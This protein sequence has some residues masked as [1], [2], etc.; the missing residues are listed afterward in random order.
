MHP[1]GKKKT[2]GKEKFEKELQQP[3]VRKGY[4]GSDKL[5][6]KVAIITGGDSGIGSSVAVHFAMEGA[7]V[8]INYFKSD[9][10]AQET[11]KAVE[12]AGGKCLLVKGDVAKEAFCKKLV[13]QTVK[14]FGS[15][16]I[17]INNAGM[18]EEDKDVEGISKAQLVRT[19]EV[20]MFSMFYLTQAA[21][22][23]LK[24]G[25]AIVNTASITA[26]RGS[27]HLMDYAASKGAIVAYTRSLAKNL[28]AQ[29]IR[30]NAVA[31]GPVWTPLVVNA[32]DAEHLKKFGK[33]TP[34]G[35]AGY[36]YEV[37]PAFVYLAGEESSYVTGQVIHVNGGD[38][39]G[40]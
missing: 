1:E 9:D 15:L 28:A 20:N 26:Y 37:A 24:A 35:R 25:S 16:D 33:E 39:V 34:L 22:P 13:E 4:K 21:M 32:F 18:H 7:S 10:D 11:K 5:K 19:F 29:K 27:P 12:A 17:L 40:G 3:P 31:P 8:C 23:H 6:G 14:E 30:V 2:A 36:P 38:V